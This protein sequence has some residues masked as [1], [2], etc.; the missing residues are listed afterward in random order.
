MSSIACMRFSTLRRCLLVSVRPPFSFKKSESEFLEADADE[1][2]I[3]CSMH[4]TQSIPFCQKNLLSRIMT[5]NKILSARKSHIYY[6]NTPLTV[7]RPFSDSFRYICSS[8]VMSSV[9][10]NACA[11]KFH[12]ERLIATVRFSAQPKKGNQLFISLVIH[13]YHF[14]IQKHLAL[15]GGREIWVRH[16]TLKLPMHLCG[17][18]S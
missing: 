16:T 2:I 12:Q 11:Q 10:T 14:R 9:C 17:N 8:T 7:K 4:R 6:G 5:C 13:D 3:V 15:I 18:E 1:M